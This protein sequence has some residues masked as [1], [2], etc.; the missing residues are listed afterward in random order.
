MLCSTVTDNGEV[1][2]DINIEQPVIDL[3]TS[4]ESVGTSTVRPN[5]RL[6]EAKADCWQKRVIAYK[7]G[8]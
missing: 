6:Q 1:V 7:M 5:N 4:R 8:N 3:I 2:V